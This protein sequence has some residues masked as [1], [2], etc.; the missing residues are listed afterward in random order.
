[1]TVTAQ[2][3][4]PMYLHILS[5]SKIAVHTTAPEKNLTLNGIAYQVLQILSK[6]GDSLSDNFHITVNDHGDYAFDVDE[7]FTLNRFRADIYGE[8]QIDDL[9]EEQ[10]NATAAQ[11]MDHLTG[12]SG[13]SIVLYGKDAYTR[14][15]LPHILF[16]KSLPNRKSSKLRSCAIS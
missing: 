3:S 1:M 4:P 6:N 9:S 10:K 16:R 7:G 15:N 12:S 11:I 5:H 13:F 8:A 2:L 14:K